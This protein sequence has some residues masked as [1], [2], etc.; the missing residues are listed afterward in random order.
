MSQHSNK[1]STREHFLK[2]AKP[3]MKH[4]LYVLLLIPS[5]T[6]GQVSMEKLTRKNGLAYEQGATTPFTGKA[7]DNFPNGGVKTILEYKDGVPNG[8]IKSWY[9]KDVKQAEGFLENGQRTGIWKLYYES[10]KL[11]KQTAYL[12][13]VENGEEIFWS[14]NGTIQKKDSYINGKLNGKYEWYYDNGQKKQ[15]GYFV[16]GK[17]DSTWSEWYEN[18]KPKML[19]HFTNFEKNGSWTWWDENGNITTTKSYENGLLKVGSDNFDTYLEKMESAISDRD[20][21]EAV[22]NVKLA[23]ETITDKTENNKI[24][25]GLSV[26]HSRCYSLF[27]HYRQAEK[28]LLDILGLTESQSQII[29]S[30]HLDKSPEKLQQVIKEI[31]NTDRPKFRISNHIV[32]ALCHNILGDTVNLQKE[33]QLMMEKGQMQDWIINISMELYKLAA[34]RFNN[35]YTLEDIN[36][37][38]KKEG[39]TEKLELAKAAYLIRTENFEDAGIIAD[40]YLK[41][42]DKNLTALLLKADIEMA[43]GNTDKMKIYE[44]KAKLIDPNAFKDTNK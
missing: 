3:A 20:F 33:Q 30:S 2:Y 27:S 39:L 18:G 28:T 19:G 16:D 42:N 5:L 9:S 13:N 31:S 41:I 35:Y 12:N 44:A 26:Y 4:I 40:K 24:F 32:L 7:V 25:M 34:E 17:E 43:Y 37:Q 1:P 21:K 29:Q 14:E 38:I 10:G 6:F 22:K 36:N 11:K 23:E 8:E 15:E